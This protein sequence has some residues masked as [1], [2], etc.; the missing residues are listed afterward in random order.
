MKIECIKN[1]EGVPGEATKIGGIYYVDRFSIILDSDG[2]AYG[3]VYTDRDMRECLGKKLLNRFK[4]V[5]D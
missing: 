3:F 5:A 2:D 1:R 4:T